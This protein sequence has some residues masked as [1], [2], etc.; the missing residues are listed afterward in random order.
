MIVLA[1]QHKFVSYVWFQL[2]FKG[3]VFKETVFIVAIINFVK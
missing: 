3:A 2:G 1:T